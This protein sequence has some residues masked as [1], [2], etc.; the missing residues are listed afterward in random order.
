M[1]RRLTSALAMVVAMTAA[2]AAL[3][4]EAQTTVKVYH[5]R[6]S[7]MVE[8]T[9][10]VLPLLS[11]SG[12][13]TIQPGGDRMTVQDVSEVMERVSSV[14]AKLDRSPERY[15]IR[16]ELLA[17]SSGPPT[18]GDQV[19]VADR[20][21]RMFP[22]TSYRRI[23]AAV[24]EGEVGSPAA[25]DLGE[26]NRLSFQA[27]SL[28]PPP[29]APWGMADTGNRVQLQELSLARLDERPDGEQTTKEILRTSVFLSPSQEVF[30]GAGGSEGSAQG[31]VLILHAESI[32]RR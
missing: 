8:A 26:G 29:D 7:S 25:A 32:G 5:I 20:V 1:A 27:V 11:A 21:R 3:A 9:T 24:F 14:L 30:I 12:I 19:E 13:V 31:L 22:F 4:Q 18:Q 10:A 16:A 15:R 2:A 23:G 6:H 17:G 28:Q